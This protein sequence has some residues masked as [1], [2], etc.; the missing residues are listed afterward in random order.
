MGIPAKLWSF[1]HD[2]RPTLEATECL[3]QL[4]R[5]HP[6]YRCRLLTDAD[7]P[8]DRADV[9][10]LGAQ[11]RSDWVRLRWLSREGGVWLDAT[12]VAFRPLTA[13]WLDRADETAE[14]QGFHPSDDHPAVVDSWAL[15]CPAGSPYVCAWFAE[16]DRA[17]RGGL[18]AYR[19]EIRARYGGV[20]AG[21]PGGDGALPYLSVYAAAVVARDARPDAVVR[22]RPG[23]APGGPLD[24]LAAAGG[25]ST[26]VAWRVCHE[27]GLADRGGRVGAM[28]KLRGAEATLT[29]WF[30]VFGRFDPLADVPRALGWGPVA[31]PRPLADGGVLLAEVWA[32]VRWQWTVARGRTLAIGLAALA[33]ALALAAALARRRGTGGP[34]RRARAPAPS[35]GD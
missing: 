28:I 32:G 3:A 4:W 21:I 26:R 12:V 11:A 15:A 8:A 13:D 10:A 34:R 31:R 7:I 24:L 22:T 29:R 20:P 23:F 6:E 33:L 9:R 27:R 35:T 17:V 18:G 2:G 1:W 14:L 19:A 16:F 5:L 25:D 30:R